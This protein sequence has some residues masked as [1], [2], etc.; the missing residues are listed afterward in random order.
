MHSLGNYDLGMWMG[1]LEKE[2]LH[3][4]LQNSNA[5]LQC[6]YPS[7][8]MNH[9]VK[10]TENRSICTYMHAIYTRK[11]AHRTIYTLWNTNVQRLY[12][13][14]LYYIIKWL[15][16]I[17]TW[18]SIYSA[19]YCSPLSLYYRNNPFPSDYRGEQKIQASDW[20]ISWRVKGWTHGPRRAILNPSQSLLFFCVMLW[21]RPS[22]LFS[23]RA[24]EI[25]FSGCQWLCSP[26]RMRP[27]RWEKQ[28][29][30]AELKQGPG[31]Y[32]RAETSHSWSAYPPLWFECR[33]Q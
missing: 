33:S 27:R 12:T 10:Y 20:P 4:Y 18:L 30:V 26:E 17:I 23:G 29:P 6:M 16:N 21:E 28:K 9:Y 13:Y 22:F 7:I 25:W 3:S 19:F 5:Y 11:H 32:S 15:I 14:T 8:F 1:S 31:Q 24:V 2:K